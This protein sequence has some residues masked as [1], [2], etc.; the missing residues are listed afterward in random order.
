MIVPFRQQVVTFWERQSRPQRITLIA[1]LLAAMVLV[2]VLVTWANTPT[3]AVAFSGL[4]EA[5]AG[6]IVEKLA[7]SNIAYQLKD[8]GTILV[9]SANVYE[10]RLMMARQGIP[11]NSTVGFEVFSQNTLGMTEFTQKVNYQRALEGELERTIASLDSVEAVRVHIVQPEKSLFVNDQ[12]PSTASVTLKV[13]LGKKV[14]ASQVTAITN[15]VANSVE[16]MKADKVVVV[17]TNGKMLTNNTQTSDVT[18][19]T[20]QAETHNQMEQQEAQNIKQKVQA[21]LDS[22]LGPNKSTV[23]AS[24]VM[25]WSQRETTAQTF[26]PTPAAVRSSKV[27][28]EAYTLNGGTSGIPGAATNLPTAVPTVSATNTAT[29]YQRSE[30]TYNYEITQTQS[31]EVIAP[32]Q[33]KRV[34]VSVMVDSI[35]DA[36]LLASLKT[37]VTAAAGIDTTRGDTVAVE[38]VTFDRTYTTQLETDLTQQ[39]QTDLYIRIGEI[40]A[41]VVALLAVLIFIMRLFGSLR[42]SAGEQWKPIMRPVS[43]FALA[44]GMAGSL[45]SGSMQIP[46]LASGGASGDVLAAI[47]AGTESPASQQVTNR[48]SEI[49]SRNVP[50]AEDEQLQKLMSDLVEE[51]PATVAEIIQMWL[52]E[53]EKRHG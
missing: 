27:V 30:Q 10:V 23:Q 31:K 42:S 25:D 22:V 28:N 11:Q 50:S 37:A 6:Q 17:D 26:N 45:P 12:Q 21:M 18:N 39:S 2:P 35:K 33:V 36:T 19:S 38:S 20:T 43:E 49:M 8:T 34:S 48:I 5:D 1:L 13:K 47:Q 16:G 40:A 9:P 41:G 44:S 46:S 32:G 14:D 4:T 7:A 24:V 15:L 51:S 29:L 3:Y 53:D 52:A